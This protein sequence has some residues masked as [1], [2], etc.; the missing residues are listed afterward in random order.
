MLF[1]ST[2]TLSPMM[3]IR[4]S[5]L[6][7]LALM[8][9]PVS[10]QA[11]KS[12]PDGHTI[13]GLSHPESVAAAPDG[14]AFFA[15]NIGR[16]LAPLAKDGDGF[17]A[18]L[19]PDG[20]IETRRFLPAPASDDT[21]HAP[22]GTV[23]LDGH[24]YTADVDRV[25]GFSLSTRAQTIEVDL[26]A[27]GVTF[28]N[29]IAVLDGETLVASATKQGRLYRIDL[30]AGTATAL[31]VDIPGVNGV[32][33]AAGTGRLYAVTFGGPQAGAL[34]TLTVDAAGRVQEPSSRTIQAGDRLD[35]VVRRGTT[36]LISAWGEKGTSGPALYRVADRGTGTVTRLPLSDWSGA[37]DFD[38]VEGGG[39]WVP[40]LPGN[41]VTIV[42]P[43]QRK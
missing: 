38:C 37:A 19:A 23:V 20:T 33:Y 5:A 17:I 12:P 39:C 26:Q 14:S 32:A 28:L 2:T 25:V 8:L 18:R 34:W 4:S 9:L 7:G 24:L 15:A 21:L 6:F 3:C 11:Q 27:H 43:E 42:R 31:D 29:D 30:A 10:V 41:A 16:T 13:D 40:D 22:K 1:F 35:G 36:V